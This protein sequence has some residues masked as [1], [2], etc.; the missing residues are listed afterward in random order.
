MA[1]KGLDTTFLH[2]GV[3]R[4]D[5]S[6]IE[7]ISLNYQLDADWVKDDLLREF[8]EKKVS[9]QELDDKSIERLIDKALQKIK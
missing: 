5:M 3:R 9:K 1:K 4:E 7:T 2:Y 8:H 6:L